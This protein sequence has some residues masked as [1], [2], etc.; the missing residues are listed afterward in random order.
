M[1]ET[2]VFKNLQKEYAK[3]EILN[4]IDTIHTFNKNKGGFILE[5]SMHLTFPFNKE[6]YSLLLDNL[7]NNMVLNITERCNYRCTYCGYGESYKYTRYHSNRSMPWSVIRDA[8]D[9]YLPRALQYLKRSENGI[10]IGFYGGEPLLE[11]ENIFKAIEY[12]RAYHREI[13][14][15]VHYNISTNGSL[16]DKSTIIKLIEYDFT[17]SISLDGS[18][19]IHDRY[20]VFKNGRG[21]FETVMHN[22]LQVKKI[23]PDYF[24]TR[25][26]INS[27]IAPEYKLKEMVDFLKENFPDHNIS[28]NPV[29]PY[30]TTFFKNFNMPEEIKKYN[31]D[32]GQIREE[33]INAKLETNT[34]FLYNLFDYILGFF[35]DRSLFELPNEMYPNGIC[36]P[37]LKRFVVELDGSFHICE[38]INPGFTIGDVNKGFEI[39]KIFHYIDEYIKT[40]GKCKGCWAVRLCKDCFI[41]AIKGA[42][43]NIDRKKKNCQ[44]KR[45]KM[46]EE[47]KAFVD[48]SDRYPGVLDKIHY[49][50]PDSD[51]IKFAFHFLDKE[52]KKHSEK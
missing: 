42:E 27:V 19:D 50:S 2:E 11:K 23:N 46:L 38:K 37:G 44:A 43:F 48:I 3:E 29:S 22:L 9:F 25:V 12:I 28:F 24:N 20:R 41:S 21:S 14:P 52:K 4:A 51:V 33:Y 8:I 34:S 36:A 35:A 10:Y 15:H 40:T 49:T 6:E 16:L 30:D 17:L 47:M 7:L 5:K 45:D 26:R 1:N 31:N 39:D 32:L 18:K 13:F